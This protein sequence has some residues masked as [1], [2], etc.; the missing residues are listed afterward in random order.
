[1]TP[2]PSLSTRF[3]AFVNPWP[4]ILALDAA[5]YLLAA[6]LVAI[7]LA[8]ATDKYIDLRRVRQRTPRK[9][10]SL[11]EFRNSMATAIVFSIVGL[12]VYHGAIHGVFHVYSD[13]RTY[14]WTYWI[15]SLLL[16][17][18]A[19][20]AYFYWAHRWMHSRFVFRLV[21][22]THHQSIAPTLWAAYSFS[23]GEALVQAVFLPLFL[24]LL[25][26]HGSV[27]FIWMGHQVLRNAVGHCGVELVP[28]S[29]LSTWWGRWFTT[30]LHHDMHHATGGHNYGLYFAWWDRCCGTEHPDYRQRLQRLIASTAPQPLVHVGGT[31]E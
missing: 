23:V 25:P 30:T 22:G 3:L 1:M 28:H 2:D 20:D 12:F 24:L 27:L 18:I 31:T 16:I 26:M 11:R 5:R 17:V 14:G 15:L 6:A 13:G 19:H 10:Q 21:H 8:V 4:A 9:R 7:V 29:W